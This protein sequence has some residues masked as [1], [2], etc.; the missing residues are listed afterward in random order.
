M[1]GILKGKIALVTGAASG[2]G[3]ASALALARAGARVVVAD[4]AVDGG[5]ETVRLIAAAAGQAK[6]IR[7]DVTRAGDVEAAVACAVKNYGGLDIAHNNAGVLAGTSLLDADAESLFE[8]V[9][10]IN[11]MSVM[12][13][14]KFE[15]PAMLERGG[16]AIVNTAS[17]MG[18]V[19]SVAGNWAYTASKHGVVGLSKSIA[20]EY[21]KQN[22]RINAVCPGAVRTPMIAGHMAD[23]AAERNVAAT[24]PIG[25]VAEPEEIAAA[26]LWLASPAASYVIGAAVPVD[27]G[28]TAV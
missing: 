8:R 16:G 20:A 7:T 5:E 21:A 22:I 27:G 3:R 18:L 2:I 9:L 19:A 28:F 10:A 26:V 12:L 24:H 23:A 15:I 11:L 1:A 4:M 17:T 6:F 25:R 14:M 13:S